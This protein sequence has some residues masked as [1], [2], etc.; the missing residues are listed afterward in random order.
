[1]S[2]SSPYFLS[3]DWGTT[4]FRLRLI[5]RDSLQIQ[6]EHKSNQ[7]IKSLHLAAKNSIQSQFDYFSDFIVAQ[8]AQNFGEYSNVPLVCT[9]MLSSTLG[10]K[11]L[12]YAVMPFPRSGEDLVTEEIN[13]GNGRELLLVSG[14]R[15]ELGFMRGEEVQAIGLSEKLGSEGIL[16]LP[17]TH[18]KHVSFDQEYFTEV[19]NF[20]T[21][22]LFNV[23]VRHSILS[24]A[25]QECSWDDN[26]RNTFLSGVSR[27]INE[28]LGSQLLTTRAKQMFKGQS[29]GQGYFY[30]SGLIIGDEISTLR[31]HHGHVYMA[32][33]DATFPLYKL[34]LESLISPDRLSMFEN[35][36]LRNALFTGQR[37]MLHNHGW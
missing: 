8:L 14:A 9:G 15:S 12:P 25:A 35:Q 37:K 7:G 13:L 4:N 23:L 10:L 17:G 36:T 18:S 20:M 11:E 19:K 33:S 22:E 1:M 27:G 26:Y 6:K 32:S 3:C 31:T 34:A 29:T 30:L 16:I 2:Q 21:G 28:G 5:D 24:T